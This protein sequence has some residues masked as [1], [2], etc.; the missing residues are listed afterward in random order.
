MRILAV[1]GLAAV[2]GLALWFVVSAWSRF[3][4]DAIPAYG[5][6]AIAGGV[7]MSLLVGGGLMALAF[8]SSRKG[9][10]DIDRSDR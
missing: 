6:A 7:V 2:L 8:Y 9:Y 4:G 3:G 10:D 5:Y 1:I